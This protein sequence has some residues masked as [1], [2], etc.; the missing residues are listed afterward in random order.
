MYACTCEFSLRREYFGVI[1]INTVIFAMGVSQSWP[2]HIDLSLN[3]PH[4]AAQIV[5]DLSLPSSP[6]GSLVTRS[7]HPGRDPN[8]STPIGP[9]H[10]LLC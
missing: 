4:P 6:L 10:A 3:Q 5:Y 1:L 8:L 2:T 7:I 9:L